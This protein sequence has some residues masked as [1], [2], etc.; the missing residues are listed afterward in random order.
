MR[1]CG[2]MV[3][4]HAF[5]FLTKA[6]RVLFWAAYEQCLNGHIISA[7]K[8]YFRSAPILKG[9]TAVDN[10]TFSDV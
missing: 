2:T 1:Q 10:D 6:V 9:G 4:W 3:G 7:A 5:G 8:A